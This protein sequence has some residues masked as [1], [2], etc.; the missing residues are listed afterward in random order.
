MFRGV[1]RGR[2]CL[3]R[4]KWSRSCRRCADP[5][6][7]NRNCSAHGVWFRHRSL[8]RQ[9]CHC[10]GGN[11]MKARVLIARPHP[12]GGV[13]PMTRVVPMRGPVAMKLASMPAQSPLVSVS[14]GRSAAQ[15]ITPRLPYAVNS[16]FTGASS[17]MSS[18]TTVWWAWTRLSCGCRDCPHR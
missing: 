14:T 8:F 7:P 18:H 17:P 1:D 10:I 13:P 2:T 11:V 5:R 9:E 12:A 15:G 3:S 16:R 6:L 4:W